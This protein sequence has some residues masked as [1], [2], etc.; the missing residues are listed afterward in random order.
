MPTFTLLVSRIRFAISQ[1][2]RL[3]ASRR[4]GVSYGTGHRVLEALSFVEDGCG[5]GRSE[6]SLIVV[7]RDVRASVTV[8]QGIRPAQG[9]SF[10]SISS[11]LEFPGAESHICAVLD[12]S[13]SGLGRADALSTAPSL[14]GSLESP[15]C[16]LVGA[17]LRR[18]EASRREGRVR[19]ARVPPTRGGLGV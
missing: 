6:C 12:T 9:P 14:R 3:C 1:S 10:V 15:S 13:F 2:G 16:E 11:G 7:P 18:R 8:S 5:L 17:G 19:R 4:G